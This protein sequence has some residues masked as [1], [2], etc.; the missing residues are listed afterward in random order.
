MK[1]K[2]PFLVLGVLCAAWLLMQFFAIMQMPSRLILHADSDGYERLSVFLA[3]N[4]TISS[5]AAYDKT[6]SALLQDS[7]QRRSI[8]CAEMRIWGDYEP[9]WPITLLAGQWPEPTESGKVVISDKQA[10][11]LFAS[12]DCVGE[13]VLLNGRAYQ[14]A[15]VYQKTGMIAK[16]AVMGAS[17]VFAV[18]DAPLHTW[19]VS[20]AKGKENQAAYS[21][22][23]FLEEYGAAD[24]HVTLLYR[25]QLRLLFILM[26][27]GTIL[28]LLF[29]RSIW[30][31]YQVRLYAANPTIASAASIAIR[32]LAASA[33]IAFCIERFPWSPEALPTAITIPALSDCLQS[34]LIRWNTQC[35][36]PT[37]EGCYQA[38]IN[39]GIITMCAALW[40][41]LWRVTRR[42]NNHAKLEG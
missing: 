33:L 38:W 3:G 35:D 26:L 30:R 4:E 11:T 9:P 34:F 18:T 32:I 15:G 6:D 13:A 8:Q 41:S 36:Q 12:Y 40:L 20:A 24:A 14:V 39:R 21:L 37:M 31:H 2:L 29:V 28:L 42:R 23:Q 1:R 5:Y 17:E 10:S 25:Q 27:Q 16:L 22:T 19:V 7:N